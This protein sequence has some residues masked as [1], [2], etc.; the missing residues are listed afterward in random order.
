MRASSIDG[1]EDEEWELLF[2]QSGD[3]ETCNTLLA[4]DDIRE[5]V[6]NVP[7]DY[8]LTCKEVIQHED[9]LKNIQPGNVHNKH[10]TRLEWYHQVLKRYHQFEIKSD[11]VE[12]FGDKSSAYLD[13]IFRG[14][15]EQKLED[16]ARDHKMEIIWD[17]EKRLYLT[18]HIPA[19]DRM[20]DKREIRQLDHYSTCKEVIQHEDTLKSFPFP[21]DHSRLSYYRRVLTIYHQFK[22]KS[23]FI[24]LF[25]DQTPK[26]VYEIFGKNHEEQLKAYARDHKM[27][28]TWDGRRKLYNTNK[29]DDEQI[30]TNTSNIQVDN[31]STCKE[32]IEHEDNIKNIRW[33]DALMG[34]RTRLARYKRVLNVYH[35]FEEK[36]E[37]MKL[38][39]GKNPYEI[40]VIFGKNYANQM[41]IDTRDCKMEII[42][43]VER[44]L[45][46][47]RKSGIGNESIKHSI[48]HEDT[49]KDIRPSDIDIKYYPRL[50]QYRRVLEKHHQFKEKSDFIELFGDQHPKYVYDIFGKNHKKHLKSHASDRNMEITWDAERALGGENKD[51][52]AN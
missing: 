34:H 30:V 7:L 33:M 6:S 10:I 49:I 21:K 43:D 27:E 39:G 18:R 28:I 11:F 47:T 48:Q 29:V 46:I 1:W 5:E 41:T 12:L 45:Y 44:K 38:F 13:M 42:W 35:Q 52:D 2:P 31:Y 37:F 14:D 23:D 51:E 32:V 17:E 50:M 16:Y 26:H 40:C 9:T 36:S 15:C 8:Y 3:F 22:E 4:E 24:E 20:V 25:G 19:C